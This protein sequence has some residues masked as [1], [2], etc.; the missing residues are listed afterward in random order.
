MIE[1]LIRTNGCYVGAFDLDSAVHREESFASLMNRAEL[2]ASEGKQ[3]WATIFYL[4]DRLLSRMRAGEI[5]AWTLFF[6]GRFKA[7][8]GVALGE[9]ESDLDKTSASLF[10]NGEHHDLICPSGKIAVASLHELG[11]PSLRPTLEVSP[12]TYR[13]VFTEDDQQINKHYE[14]DGEIDYPVGDGPDWVLTLKKV[15]EH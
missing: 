13:V 6:Y 1:T 3:P 15:K 12:G 4:N 2:D 10:L 14:F 9:E 8:I 7:Q 11:N 5:L